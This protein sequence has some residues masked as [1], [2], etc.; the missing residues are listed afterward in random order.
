MGNFSMRFW[1]SV[2]PDCYVDFT[3][4]NDENIG[5]SADEA[6]KTLSKVNSISL[7]PG[8]I[9]GLKCGEVWRETLVPPSS[10]V[11]GNPIKI[12]KYGA[13]ADPI[14]SGADAGAPTTPVREGCIRDHTGKGFITIDGIELAY[15]A[16]AGVVSARW[17]GDTEGE[18]PN[19]TVQNCAFTKCGTYMFGA[20]ITIQDN[21]FVGPRPNDHAVDG[22][23]HIRGLVS[24]NAQVLR[25]TISG[26]DSRG[27]WIMN[28]PTAPSVRDNIIHDIAVTYGEA[29][30]GYGINFDGYG[31]VINGLVTCTGNHVYNCAAD[32]VFFEN[33]S[34]GSLVHGNLIH[35]VPR[36]IN[37]KNYAELGTRPE[38][39]GNDVNAQIHYNITYGVNTGVY[40]QSV[41]G[42]HIH[43][44]M[45]DGALYGVLIPAAEATY[46]G[47]LDI[48]NNIFG[49]NLDYVLRCVAPWEDTCTYFDFNRVKIG[50][51]VYETGVSDELT[52]AELQA[53]SDAL[54]SFTTDPAFVDGANH[55]YHLQNGSPCINAGTDLD[56]TEDYDGVAVGATPEIGAFEKV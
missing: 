18:T 50:N 37:Y 54:N 45:L 20:N 22:A 15:P 13:G 51:V 26:F 19:W 30:E 2:I 14:I 38:Q 10:G 39:R 23:V 48:R 28:K 36:A 24:T 53:G 12:T 6:W 9:V 47:E 44:N 55:D 31:Q 52:L 1:P 7:D 46:A 21:V 32:G 41:K 40:V 4:G 35:D 56:L 42:L 16:L 3:N 11:S 5:T 8:D 43:N 49:D 29:G 17:I 25:N 34:G 27:I 33:C